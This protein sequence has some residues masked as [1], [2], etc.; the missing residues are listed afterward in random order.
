MKYLFCAAMLFIGIGNSLGKT[1]A[2]PRILNTYPINGAQN[3]NPFTGIGITFSQPLDPNGVIAAKIIVRGLAK[4]YEG[5]IILARNRR[6]VIFKPIESFGLGDKINVKIENFETSEGSETPTFEMNFEVKP[7]LVFP[8]SNV[9]SDDPVTESMLRRFRNSAPGNS[10]K[11]SNLA[12]PLSLPQINIFTRNNPEPGNIYLANFRFTGD[13]VNTYRMVMDQ[14]GDLT[15]ADGGG[16]DYFGDF[17]P[18]PDG[19]YSFYDYQNGAFFILDSAYQLQRMVSASKGY[20]TDAHEIRLNE[21]GNYFIIAADYEQVDMRKY[22]ENGFY[23]ATVLVPII[24]EIDKD[25]NVIFQWRSID[26]FKVTDATHED[27]SS[28]YVD[29]CHMNAIEFDEDSNLLIS[30]RHLDEITK[31]DKQTGDIIWRWGGKNNQFTFTNDTVLFSHQHAIR[32]NTGGT[33]SMFDNGNYHP[34]SVWYSRAIEYELDQKK[35][36]ATKVWEF[37]H[38]PDILSL[39]MGNVQRLPNANTFIGWG[40]SNNVA[41]TEVD[42]ANN[43]IFEMGM[44]DQNYS[45]RAYKYSAD[46]IHSNQLDAGPVAAI[47]ATALT[48][49]PNPVTEKAVIHLLMQSE[50]SVDLSLVDEIGREVRKIFNGSLPVGEHNFP[51]AIQ[52]LPA[53]MYSVC[54]NGGAANSRV[55]MIIVK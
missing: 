8:D 23:P 50:G 29:F 7:R 4:S 39:A 3:V 51:I 34:Q 54:L 15:K 27:L 18:N 28:S 11:F 37:R 30:S 46:Y 32:L 33:Y 17:K 22:V 48:V 24:E 38:T 21:D 43:T 45:Y 49:N 35:L 52:P 55:N 25:T 14:N 5:H 9:H 40:E 42:P 31:I 36:T 20:T 19:T 16:P 44:T 41:A 47:S 12:A 1:T 53:G 2:P 13:Q 26:H 10:A 6:T